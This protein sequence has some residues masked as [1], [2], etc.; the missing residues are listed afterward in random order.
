MNSCTEIDY[1]GRPSISII[2]GFLGSFKGLQT[3]AAGFR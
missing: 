2:V 3:Q 1:I